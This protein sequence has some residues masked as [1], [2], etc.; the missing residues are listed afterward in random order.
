MV[1]IRPRTAEHCPGA[2]RRQTVIDR[3]L[4]YA[5]N[6]VVVGPDAVMSGGPVYANYHLVP[7]VPTGHCWGS[8]HNESF[9]YSNIAYGLLGKVIEAASGSSYSTYVRQHIV[10]PL[11]LADTGPEI[12]AQMQERLATGYTM[13]R[14]GLPC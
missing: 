5:L 11:G 2:L 4:T 10:D 6:C 13:R 1:W 9:K 3:R 12:N 7:L 8:L 14:Y